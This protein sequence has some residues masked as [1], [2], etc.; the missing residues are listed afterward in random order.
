MSR[1]PSRLFWR[2][3]SSASLKGFLNPI[4]MVFK[5]ALISWVL[6]KLLIFGFSDRSVN[7]FYQESWTLR[8]RALCKLLNCSDFL[9]GFGGASQPRKCQSWGNKSLKSVEIDCCAV[10]DQTITQWSKNSV[11]RQL[12]RL[13]LSVI[14]PLLIINFSLFS[15]FFV[16]FFVNLSFLNKKPSLCTRCKVRSVLPTRNSIW[17]G[18]TPL[19]VKNS[20]NL[21]RFF[22]PM[23]F[24]T[25]RALPSKNA[26]KSFDHEELRFK[27]N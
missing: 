22:S 25:W 19:T 12:F 10:C 26:K 6:F 23:H 3:K 4:L 21:T 9:R 24:F 16:K 14:F 5:D 17:D 8:R 15:T 20:S 1:V 18:S 13:I 2:S 11:F 27:K 7:G